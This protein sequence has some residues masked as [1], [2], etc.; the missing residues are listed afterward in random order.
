MGISRLLIVATRHLCFIAIL[1]NFNSCV[2]QNRSGLEINQEWGNYIPREQLFK[3]SERLKKIIDNIL[4]YA[5]NKRLPLNKLSVT[6]IDI[7]TRERGDFQESIPRYPASVVKIFWLVA[8]YQKIEQRDV[9]ESMLSSEIS[10]M[11]N[12]SDNNASNQVLDVITGTKSTQ[13]SF[14]NCKQNREN[15][16]NFFYRAN[17]SKKINISQKTV[18][19]HTDLK[20]CDKKLRDNGGKN[21]LTTDSTARLMYEIINNQSITSASSKKMKKLLTRNISSWKNKPS[22]GEIFNPVKGFFGQDLPSKEIESVISKAGMVDESKG[23]V[24]FIKSKD[25]KVQYILAVFGDDS[26]YS[27]KDNLFPEISSLVYEKMKS[28]K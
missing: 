24:A 14:E 6:L 16:N 19:N 27:K 12:K 4:Q 17:Y 3:R 7:Q 20:G 21:K 8:I 23:E 15:L 18:L 2:N 26:V 13:I 9:E 22:N 1:I 28:N 11:I 5:K 10:A 25:G